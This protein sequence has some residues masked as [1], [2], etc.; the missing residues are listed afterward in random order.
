[1]KDWKEELIKQLAFQLFN[2]SDMSR[3]KALKFS[4]NFIN[5]TIFP[6]LSQQREEINDE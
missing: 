3:E 1:M 5:E 2:C 6:L 4:S